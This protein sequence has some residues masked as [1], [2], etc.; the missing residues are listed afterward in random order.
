TA[1]PLLTGDGIVLVTG[2]GIAVWLD[3]ATG[4]ITGDYQLTGLRDGH[5]PYRTAGPGAPTAPVL[6]GRDPVVVLL[7]GSAWRLRPGGP[8][9][10]GDAGAPV[11]TR[12]AALRPDTL[13][14][15]TAGALLCFLD[16]GG[17]EAGR[18]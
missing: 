1:G 5:G 7:D 3:P 13:A 14:V 16:L 11:T 15:L 17:H 4:T 9:L 6:A 12:P 18:R 8:E 10:A 2:D